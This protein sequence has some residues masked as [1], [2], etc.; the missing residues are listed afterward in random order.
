VILDR[1][2]M[3][4]CGNCFVHSYDCF[5]YIDGERIHVPDLGDVE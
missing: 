4:G 5:V 2:R 3:D 1:L